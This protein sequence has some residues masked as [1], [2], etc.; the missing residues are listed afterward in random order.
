MVMHIAMMAYHGYVLIQ[1]YEIVLCT[2]MHVPLFYVGQA[3][4]ASVYMAFVLCRCRV[5]RSMSTHKMVLGESNNAREKALRLKYCLNGRIASV[6]AYMF[7][8]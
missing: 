5:R 6:G 8:C 7:L 4:N 2:Y 1:L 3:E